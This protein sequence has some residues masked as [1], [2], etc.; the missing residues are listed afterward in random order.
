MRRIAI[1][2]VTAVVCSFV[3]QGQSRVEAEEHNKRGLTLYRESKL[4]EAEAEYRQGMAVARS[5]GGE[6]L[7]EYTALISNLA[8]VLQMQG[9]IAE[10]RQLLD[11]SISI[12]TTK[13]GNRGPTLAHALNNVALMEMAE[14]RLDQAVALLKRAL[15]LKYVDDRTRAGTMHNLAA[16]YFDMGQRNKAESMF[17]TVIEE[18]DRLGMKDE[19][20]PALTYLAKLVA[21]KGDRT[22]AE[23]LLRKALD[24]RKEAFGPEHL[25]VSFSLTDLGDFETTRGRYAEAIEYFEQALQVVEPVLGKDH[26]FSVAT[27]FH[28]GEAKRRQGRYEE[29]LALYERTGKILERHYGPDHARL[30]AVYKGAALCSSKLKRKQQAKDYD[31]RAQTIEN[32][33]VAYSKHTVDV[34]SFLPRK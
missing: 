24:L 32:R 27:L 29:A 3:S 11:E 23:A 20:A 34:S 7:V 21:G 1:I 28:Y 31:L 30:A 22:R 14:A 25:N 5:I 6:G 15:S 16:A 26:L 12:G 19:A 4:T 8:V 2:A 18:Y 13:L 33:T 9:R 10:A 17:Q